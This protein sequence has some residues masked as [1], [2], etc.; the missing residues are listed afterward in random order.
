MASHDRNVALPNY[1]RKVGLPN[2]R[3]RVI[4]FCGSL[5]KGSASRKALQYKPYMKVT[6]GVETD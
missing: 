4:L 5:C 1:L 2:F 3:R 6:L